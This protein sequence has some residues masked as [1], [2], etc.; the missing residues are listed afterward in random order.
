MT[1]DY[2]IRVLDALRRTERRYAREH[3][4]ALEEGIEDPRTTEERRA[5][6]DALLE[7]QAALRRYHG[8]TVREV[9]EVLDLRAAR[10]RL[11]P[12]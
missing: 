12:P 10:L 4:Q 5:V 9:D 6:L 8:A 3:C 7:C 2:D 1:L 11:P